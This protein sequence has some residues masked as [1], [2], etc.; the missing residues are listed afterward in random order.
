MIPDIEDVVA[1]VLVGPDQLRLQRHV[2]G[3]QGIG[4]NAL[5]PAKVLARV[6]GLDRRFGRRE[7][8]TIDTAIQDIGIE[9]VQRKDGKV[10]DEVADPVAAVPQCRQLSRCRRSWVGI[11]SEGISATGRCA[12]RC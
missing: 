6:P 10:G 5:A 2:I 11:V 1:F 8:L 12:R 3:E 9:R 4:N 7:F